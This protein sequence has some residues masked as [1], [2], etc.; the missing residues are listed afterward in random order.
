MN[1][2]AAEQDWHTRGFSCDIWIDPPGQ[3]WENFIHN[4]DELFMVIEGSVELEMQ[5][6]KWCPQ[7]GEEVLIPAGA[8]HSV[9]NLGSTTSRWLYGYKRTD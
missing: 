4:V 7:A 1:R 8:L 2:Q 9:R 6:K 5:G 3:I